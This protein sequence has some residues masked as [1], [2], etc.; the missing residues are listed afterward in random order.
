MNNHS[1]FI[2]SPITH[3][4]E[5]VTT[6]TAGIGNGIETYPLCDYIMQSIF[7]RM[8]G[9]Q[10]QKMK[11]ICWELATLDYEY[12]YKRYTLKPLGECSRYDEKKTIYKDIIEQIKNRI[13]DFD[14]STFIDRAELLQETISFIK[15]IFVDTNLSIW[16]QNS[17]IEFL[18]DSTL[19]Q[20]T[21]FGTN[22]NLFVNT[23]QDKYTLLYNHRNRCAHNTLSY[24]QNLPTLKTLA[25]DDYKHDNYFIRFAILILIDKIF[26]ILYNK[27]L[28]VLEDNL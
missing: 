22:D 7:L 2:L 11:C 3:I 24:Q 16:E 13:L 4:L 6:A 14:V 20:P 28:E 25:N 12:R 8:T 15:G 18:K 23:L 1:D 9:F 10:E 27:Y 5:D 19:I 26:I 17:F 21:H